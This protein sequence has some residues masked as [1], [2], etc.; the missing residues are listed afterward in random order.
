MKKGYDDK[1]DRKMTHG[2]KCRT[3]IAYDDDKQD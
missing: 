2:D 3:K 1:Q